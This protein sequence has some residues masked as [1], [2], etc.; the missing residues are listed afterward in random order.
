[1]LA[2]ECRAA[3]AS[4]TGGDSAICHALRL[5]SAP[6]SLHELPVAL[7]LIC[8]LLYTTKGSWIAVH[9]SNTGIASVAPIT[10][11]GGNAG[12]GTVWSRIS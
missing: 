5:L 7:L 8:T 12:I 3:L 4:P 1:M 10:G 11:N 9:T 2:E 6:L